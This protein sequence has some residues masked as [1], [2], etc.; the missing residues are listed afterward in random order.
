MPKTRCDISKEAEAKVK[1]D[2]KSFCQMLQAKGGLIFLTDFFVAI[3]K[4]NLQENVLIK[5]AI[6]SLQKLIRFFL[7]FSPKEINSSTL[8]LLLEQN[9]LLIQAITDSIHG[10]QGETP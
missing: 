9:L 6:L 7:D 2:R 5:Q 1:A 10:N 4:R 3:Q 8:K